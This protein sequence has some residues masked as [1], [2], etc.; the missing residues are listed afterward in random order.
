MMKWG[1]FIFLFGVPVTIWAQSAPNY[2]N[3]RYWI[4][5]PENRVLEALSPGYQPTDSLPVDVF[6]VHSTT[7]GMGSRKNASV[8]RRMIRRRTEISLQNQI[9]VF[10]GEARIFAPSYRQVKMK[11]LFSHKLSNHQAAFDTAYTDVRN[12]FLYFMN[13]WNENRPFILAG[14]GQG[15]L[16]LQRLC[17]EFYDQIQPRLV[18]VMIPG[19]PLPITDGGSV[20]RLTPPCTDSLSTGCFT[21]WTLVGSW[22]NGKVPIPGVVYDSMG[23]HFEKRS[24]SIC[25]NPVNGMHSSDSTHQLEITALRPSNSVRIPMKTSSFQATVQV[26]GDVVVIDGHSKYLYSATGDV[27]HQY[28]YSLMY[29]EVREL[30]Q[31]KI[32]AYLAGHEGN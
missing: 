1:W 10:A 25:H 29:S 18:A 17:E 16:H 21:R 15:S 28:D 13:H 14:H 5:H 8:N 12:A 9:P 7:Y 4:I 24:T 6:Y 32:K 27:L 30:V 20:K 3:T 26:K 11:L 19:H 22:A 2:S 23:Y 31:Q